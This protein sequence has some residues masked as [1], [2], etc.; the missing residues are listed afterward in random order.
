[1]T[2]VVS[3][4]VISCA[5][6]FGRAIL[7]PRM[8]GQIEN[9]ATVAPGRGLQHRDRQRVLILW[10]AIGGGHEAMASALQCELERAGHEAVSIDGLRS[11]SPR[12]DR[13]LRSTYQFQLEHAPWSYELIFH[14][15]DLTPIAGAIRLLCGL[16]FGRRLQ[17]IVERERPDL[18]VSTYPLVTATLGWL[19]LTGRLATPTVAVISD[20]GVHRLWTAPGIDRHLVVSAP[21]ARA[22]QRAGSNSAC[23]IRPPLAPAFTAL[24]LDRAAARRALGIPEDALVTL[25]TGGAWG[26][27]ALAETVDLA[28]SAG[29]FA[30]VVTGRNARLRARLERRFH[31]CPNALILGW[32]NDMPRLMAAADCLIQNAGGVTCL[33]AIALGRPIIV[34]RPIPGHG[35]LNARLMEEIGI[36][37]W[38]RG[39]DELRQMLRAMVSGTLRLSTPCFESDLPA[40]AAVLSMEPLP[41]TRSGHTSPSRSLPRLLPVAASLAAAALWI[42]LSP[43]ALAM[44]GRTLR[45]PT[46][47]DT[48]AAGEEALVVIA[49]DPLVAGA[50]QSRLEEWHVPATLLVDERGARGLHPTAEISFGIVES[51]GQRPLVNP[52]RRRQA[53]RQAVEEIQKGTGTA[54]VYFLPS[55][56]RRTRPTL[57]TLIVA[58]THARILVLSHGEPES[59]PA[60][61]IVLDTSSMTL[62][63]AQSRL[64][65]I[66]S[67]SQSR[68]LRWVPLDE[69]SS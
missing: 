45:L 68:G 39:A 26:V 28:V 46:M 27:G 55:P 33:E 10:A 24:P 59:Q 67:E 32:V 1:M 43:G 15:L 36:A 31:G 42:T 9:D 66:L 13:L 54:P 8:R 51:A 30:V 40:S 17:R 23:V 11:M 52:W 38:A 2:V 56:G 60:G 6:L 20:Y 3:V 5:V 35:R 47:D 44:T 21:S 58:P 16:L 25:I 37:R 12:L 19:R 50:L 48:P 41:A 53:V 57:V 61:V 62:D 4:M 69:V 34:Y 63:A 49:T 7:F 29:A 14:F 18:V 64:E 22:V 65:E